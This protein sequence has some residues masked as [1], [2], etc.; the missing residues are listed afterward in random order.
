VQDSRVTASGLNVVE[1]RDEDISYFQTDEING[2]QS[3]RKTVKELAEYSKTSEAGR[4]AQLLLNQSN[5]NASP[6]L[7]NQ[8]SMQT[9]TADLVQE[10]KA[11]DQALM[12]ASD[13]SSCIRVEHH[14][15]V[16][17]VKV[18]SSERENGELPGNR[19]HDEDNREMLYAPEMRITNA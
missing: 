9:R 5:S 8:Y 2:S 15:P 6:D 7:P 13:G 18:V 1:S 11:G 16:R 19:E 4:G 17:S 10:A 12:R 14:Q 3:N